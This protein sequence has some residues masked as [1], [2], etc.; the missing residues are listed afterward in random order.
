MKALG[1]K[2]LQP[3]DQVEIIAPGMPPKPGTLKKIGHFLESWDLKLILPD[4]LLG[5]DLICSNDQASRATLLKQA[6]K[7]KDSK[8]I[9]CLRGGYGAFHLLPT[10][11]KMKPTSPKI[12]MGLSDATSLHSFLVNQWGWSTLH[13]C[14]IDRFA[15]GEATK[16]E[17]SRFKKVLFGQVDS[18]SYS[19]KP[20]NGLARKERVVKAPVIG[21]NLVT[22]Q[23]NFGTR[24]QVDPR[25]HFLFL[26]EIGERAYKVH[27]ILFHLEQLGLLKKIRG[28]I[29]G[30]FTGGRE[31]GG[32][33]LVPKVL[34]EWALSQKF[35]VVSGFPSGH[36]PNQH[37]LPFGTSAQLA[38]G[39]RPR[40][41]IKTGA[42]Y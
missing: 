28:V 18:V 13:G 5:K 10:L 11:D 29:L 30:Q 21:G 39:E 14:N 20:L 32:K 42:R 8:M 34:K 31:P 35:P 23:A 16:S 4:D 41:E 1:W 15:R 22:L 6:L 2:P 12:F 9:W 27:R 33:D 25:G 36:G 7:R 40:I 37:P 38:L 17:L 26:E 19:L 24:F 3:G